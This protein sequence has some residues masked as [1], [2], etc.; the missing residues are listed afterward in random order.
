MAQQPASSSFNRRDWLA[1]AATLAAGAF[2]AT[3]VDAEEP[4]LKGR[5]HHSVVSW[6]F[7]SHWPDMDDFCQ[8]AKSA[9]CESLELVDPKHWPTLKKHG[10][11]C[12]ISSSHGFAKGLN[13]PPHQAECLAKLRERIDLSADFGCPT[14]ITFTGMRSAEPDDAVGAKNCVEALKQIAGYAEEKKVTLALEMLNSRDDSHPM[15]GHPGYQ[16]DHCDYCIDILKKVG[17]PRV[18]LLFDIYHVQIMD[19]D[20]IRRIRQHADYLAHIHTAGNPGR[21]E[22]D[23]A[24]EINYPAIMQA[25]VDV[26]Y[27]GYVGHEFIPTRDPMAGLKEAI[28]WCD[29]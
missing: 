9:G 4:K 23:Q 18:K 24:Q 11:K 22:L 13:H 26:G 21:G 25:L 7:A 17:S 16:G 14:V 12:A 20:V 15:K 19:G 10:L 6:C 27:Q 29:V 2:A 1:G 3:R 28:A 5:I 8:K